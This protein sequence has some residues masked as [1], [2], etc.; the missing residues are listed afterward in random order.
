MSHP[1][2]RVLAATLFAL[3]AACGDGAGTDAGT[4]TDSGA[5]EREGGVTLP[6]GGLQPDVGQRPDTG[7]LDGGFGDPETLL[8][9]RE[10]IAGINTW[11]NIKGTLTSTMPPLFVLHTGPLTSHEYLPAQMKFIHRGRM[12]VYYDMRASGRTSFG[13]GSSSSTITASQHAAD[14][15]DLV[16]WV[17]RYKDTTK[18]DLIGHGY[19]AG[20]A[21]LYAAAHPERVNRLVLI[22]PY[23]TNI[24]DL[25]ERNGEAGRRLSQP[26]RTRIMS[27]M[28]RQECIQDLSRCF[29]EIWN[30]QGPL[31]MCR[32]N[33]DKFSELFFRYAEPRVERFVEQELMDSRYDWAPE[34]AR[35]RARTTVIAGPCDAS[36]E[37]TAMIYASTIPAAVLVTLAGSGH[38]PMVE[39]T[40][41]FQAA[42]RAA[43]IYP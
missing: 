2:R 36:P 17:A 35:I 13:T 19:G 10:E 8:E 15:H 40:Q 16:L 14:L 24:N 9:G 31:F 33:R 28:M 3:A 12:V 11:V 5:Q 32:E 34:L 29:I 30:I 21:S 25:V 18:I 4:A 22:T 1:S 38:F 42:V 39:Q 43:L 20:I 7:P 27:I 26:D 37:R 23:P 6:D 41:P